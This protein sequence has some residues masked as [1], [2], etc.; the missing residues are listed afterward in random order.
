MC[1]EI[2]LENTRVAKAMASVRSRLSEAVEKRG[3]RAVAREIGVPEATLRDFM[4]SWSEREML[5][6]RVEAKL[7]TRNCR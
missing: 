7:S 4:K 5:V 2:D 1:K 6:C 3:R